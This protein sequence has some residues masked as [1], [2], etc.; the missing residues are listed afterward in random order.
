HKDIQSFALPTELW[1]RA[2]GKSC[3][4]MLR[5]NIKRTIASALPKT[6]LTITFG[7]PMQGLSD[8]SGC[9]STTF[10]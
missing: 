6:N 3:Y 2:F 8:E 10:F 5:C 7:D 9:K 4:P 1:H